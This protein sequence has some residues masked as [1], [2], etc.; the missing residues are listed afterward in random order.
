VNF[1][2]ANSGIIGSK[3]FVGEAPVKWEDPNEI[4][5]NFMGQEFYPMNHP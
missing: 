2:Q 3:E 1:R 4:R 5:R